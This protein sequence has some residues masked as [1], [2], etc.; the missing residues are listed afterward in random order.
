M[1][2]DTA[3]NAS[4]T[5]CGPEIDK[6]NYWI[7]QL[8]HQMKNGSFEL[9]EFQNSA[10]YYFN[11]ACDYTENATACDQGQ[12]PLA[13]PAGLRMVAGDLF[14]RAYNDSNFAQRAV[15]HMCIMPDG[16]SH[17]TKHLPR[18]PCSLLRSQVFFPSCWDGNNLDSPDH[19]SHM[20]YPGFGDYNKGICPESHPVAIISIFYEFFFNT[21]PFPDYEN[22][23][24]AMGDRT[25]Y[26]LH[27]DFINGWTDQSSLQYALETCTGSKGLHD[28]GCSIMKGQRRSLTPLHQ[29]LKIS[30]PEE[31]LGQHGPV[32]KLP[33]CNPVTGFSWE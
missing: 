14:L 11:R 2:D 16:I 22:W 29:P 25:G 17:E 33:G 10:I 21:K 32:P 5:T 18:Q 31:E 20:A 6:S 27:G 19:K 13:P 4:D 15:S 12:L 8:Y 24:Y 7:P 1:Y 26:G 23:V 9:V 30:V 28:P 3:K